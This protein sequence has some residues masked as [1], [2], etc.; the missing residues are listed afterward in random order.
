[1]CIRDS[2]KVVFLN[3]KSLRDSVHTLDTIV[4]GSRF[5][6]KVLLRDLL[7][8][9]MCIMTTNAEHDHINSKIY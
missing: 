1:M 4:C 8:V 5:R 7:N 9:P 6:P 3:L 2:S